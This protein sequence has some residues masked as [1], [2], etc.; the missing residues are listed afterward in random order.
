MERNK[1]IIKTSILGI[2]V[3]I[4]LVA[5]KAMVGIISNSIAIVLDAVN[6]LTDVLSSVITIIGT[7]L[8]NKAPDRQHPYGHGRI[9]YLTAIIIATI[10]LVA[11]LVAGKESIFKIIYPEQSKYSLISLIIIA[12]AVV[13][14]FIL[15]NHVKNVGKK[16]NSEN[17]IASGQDAFMDAILSFT[18]LVTAIINYVWNLN[19]EGYLGL[20]ISIFI[21]KSGIEIFKRTTDLMLGERAD[22]ELCIKLRNKIESFEGIQGAYDLNLHNY[23]PS[24]IVASIH[25]Q[26][27]SD[28]TAEEIHILTREIEYIIFEE[29]GIS[30]TIGIYAAND[31]GEF[32]DMK[33]TIK[34]IIDEY[35]SILQYHG[36]YVDKSKSN[37]YFDLIVDFEEKNKENIKDEIIQKI[38][39]KFPKYNF[40]IIL[41]SDISD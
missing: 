18:T 30:L 15:G 26:V 22:R 23:G 34:S 28:M 19:L 40:N 36:F 10:I 11:G 41:D 13:T 1:T 5:F 12:I 4:T 3:N 24:K 20:I 8:S 29:F 31:E 21:I 17:L 39:E 37:V 9:E 7:K 6:N 16:V 33:N 32:K 27:R 38:K 25:I 2:I 35:K 14:K